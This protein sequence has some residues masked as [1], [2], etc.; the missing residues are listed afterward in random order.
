MN[1]MNLQY[2]EEQLNAMCDSAENSKLFN[3]VI[4]GADARGRHASIYVQAE[5]SDKA[6]D[7]IEDIGAEVIE[8][9][10]SEY[11][12]DDFLKFHNLAGRSEYG[13]IAINDLLNKDLC[14][15]VPHP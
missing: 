3:Y 9:Q 14:D 4:L 1:A 12:T 8:N 10:T 13:V 7:M 2:T 6:I 15:F 11:E 5:S